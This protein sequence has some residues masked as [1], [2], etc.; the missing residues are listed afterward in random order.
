MLASSFIHAEGIGPTTERGL[1]AAGADSWRAFLALQR[2][3]KLRGG[4]KMQRLGA[5]VEA[6]CAALDAGEVEYFGARLPAG[7]LWRL[8]G[9][10]RHRAAYVD[11]E[12]TGL[13]PDI[14]EV[15]VVALH[16]GA[17][18]R[19]FVRGRDLEA[20]PAVAARYPLLVS[21]NGATFDIPFL[22]RAFP[23]F[24]PRAHLDLRYPLARLGY[25]GGL[26][27]I[28]RTAGIRRPGHLAGIDGFEAVRLWRA[29]QRGDARALATLL[30]YAREDV[31]NLVP[32]AELV[33]RQMPRLVGFGAAS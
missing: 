22:Q 29:H 6:S 7:E 17:T 9:S 28:E 16:D 3:G 2:A 21:F 18:C 11:I 23:R 12:T 14:D 5:V 27:E 20:F 30:A 10:F 24:R 1:W 31:V 19:T 4:G 8:Y 32:L 33:A 15:T 13:S 26:K 25:R